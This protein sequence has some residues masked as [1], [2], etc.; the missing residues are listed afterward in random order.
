MKKPKKLIPPK[1]QEFSLFIKIKESCVVDYHDGK[2]W[3]EWR[4]EYVSSVG[5]TAFRECPYGQLDIHKIDVSENTYLANLVYGIA[6]TYESG[7]TFGR[8]YGNLCV[9][10]LSCDIEYIKN[11]EIYIRKNGSNGNFFRRFGFYAPFE[12]F[13]ESVS[14]VEIVQF[15]VI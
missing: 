10:A 4:R 3:G 13:F 9:P 1:E 2:E 12:G 14:S 6:V 8:S 11:M 5:E 7:D 15:N